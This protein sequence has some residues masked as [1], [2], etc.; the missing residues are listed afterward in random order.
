[1]FCNI[2]KKYKLNND[3]AV[4]ES[5]MKT[6]SVPD[7]VLGVNL[8][9]VPLKDLVEGMILER[10]KKTCLCFSFLG[11]HY[12]LVETQVKTIYI[13]PSYNERLVIIDRVHCNCGHL[14]GENLR[15]QILLQGFKWQ[16]MLKQVKKFS[17]RNCRTCR[18][19]SAPKVCSN[20]PRPFPELFIL[21]PFFQKKNLSIFRVTLC[22]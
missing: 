21:F 19:L 3:G 17:K 4:T 13:V 16:G 15:N 5:V 22:H 10:K 9:N 8:D 20:T 7:M 12:H 14:N 2:K 1:M 18:E 11:T 6:K